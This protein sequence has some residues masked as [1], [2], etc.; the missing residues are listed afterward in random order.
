MIS[1]SVNDDLK[2]YVPLTISGPSGSIHVQALL[3]T[4]LNESLTLPPHLVRALGLTFQATAD[5][6]LADGSVTTFDYFAGWVEWEGEVR[7]IN[8]LS[9]EGG[10]LL[11]MALVHGCDLHIEMISGGR[12]TIVSRS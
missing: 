7:E 10:P 1:G 11:G 6:I 8:V 4:G 5:V 2:S 9:S 12:V 3:D